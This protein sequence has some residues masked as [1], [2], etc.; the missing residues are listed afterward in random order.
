MANETTT[1]YIIRE[2]KTG[3][4]LGETTM[5]DAEFARYM[6][7]AQQPEGLIPLSDVDGEK[8]MSIIMDGS[9]TVFLE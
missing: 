2:Y 1:T 3:E 6:R 8:V 4:A 7:V 9:T 5:T